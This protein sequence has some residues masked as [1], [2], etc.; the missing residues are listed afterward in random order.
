MFKFW[1]VGARSRGSHN[2]RLVSQVAKPWPYL[3]NGRSQN[4]FEDILRILF[5]PSS[6]PSSSHHILTF[7]HTLL[8]V[9]MGATLRISA[10]NLTMM[11]VRIEQ[12]SNVK[13]GVL[14][15]KTQTQILRELRTAY[16]NENALRVRSICGS[17]N[18][19]RIHRPV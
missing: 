17:T 6:Q 16:G 13:L 2:T 8:M 19:D 10:V 5:I 4:F 9:R 15:G 14:L 11:Q 12:R 1:G 3:L 18:S 7:S